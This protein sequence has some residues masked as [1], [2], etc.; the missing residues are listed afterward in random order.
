MRVPVALL[1][2]LVLASAQRALAT[3]SIIKVGGGL[4]RLCKGASRD[5]KASSAP[6]PVTT[7]DGTELSSSGEQH[8]EE[9]PPK[10]PQYQPSTQSNA[11]VQGSTR[12]VSLIGPLSSATGAISARLFPI[13]TGAMP[14]EHRVLSK[15]QEMTA[16]KLGVAKASELAA[17]RKEEW[18]E[19]PSA[20]F[21][22]LP[23]LTSIEPDAMR[24]WS[25]EQVSE[26]PADVIEQISD[27]QRRAIGQESQSADGVEAFLVL[28]D[29][30]IQAFR[31]EIA[32]DSNS[33]LRC[34]GGACS[35]DC[36]LTEGQLIAKFGKKFDLEYIWQLSSNCLKCLMDSSS[37]VL[38]RRLSQMSPFVFAHA[39]WESHLN[40]II[41]TLLNPAQLSSAS[42]RLYGHFTEDAMAEMRPPQLA[43]IKEDQWRHVPLPAYAAIGGLSAIPLA[44]IASWSREC[45]ARISPLVIE[46]T[47]TNEQRQIL[48][49]AMALRKMRATRP[50][51]PRPPS[52][53]LPSLSP[54]GEGGAASRRRPNPH[55][56]ESFAATRMASPRCQPECYRALPDDYYECKEVQHNCMMELLSWAS[57]DEDQVARLNPEIFSASTLLQSTRQRRGVKIPEELILAMTPTQIMFSHY[58]LFKAF[59]ERILY[60]LHDRSLG[61]IH[62]TQWDSVPPRAFG[63]LRSLTAIQPEAM[64]SWCIRQVQSIR[65]DALLT[66]SPHQIVRIGMDERPENREL[67]RGYIQRVFIRNGRVKPTW[68]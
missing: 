20:A 57:Y 3:E 14:K 41:L 8:L 6:S 32:S 28:A 49:E 21:G 1:V 15:W 59:T 53:R 45:V 23:S 43:A 65:E 38:E 44:V 4:L 56:V 52:G 67:I 60:Y 27:R 50:S 61:A 24:M 68:R 33:G 11:S 7:A 48:F 51:T 47:A 34:D 30:S 39:R 54:G 63:G 2:A 18:A 62:E 66:L 17:I 26:I 29:G 46:M 10:E 25:I 55:V 40:P 58:T 22:G 13:V 16:D 19:V 9:T 31:K 37:N 64:D 42:E 12:R 5:D 36:Y 35:P